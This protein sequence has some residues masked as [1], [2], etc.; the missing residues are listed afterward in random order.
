MLL[1]DQMVNA[2]RSL[3]YEHQTGLSYATVDDVAGAWKVV[4]G[5]EAPPNLYATLSSTLFGANN[6]LVSRLRDG[7]QE[8]RLRDGVV[9]VMARIDM[10][11]CNLCTA[12]RVEAVADAKLK[13]GLWGYVCRMHF[14]HNAYGLGTG[15]GQILVRYNDFYRD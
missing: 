9:A 13:Q 5:T 14:S 2:L 3:S 7:V 8:F 15:L 10:P 4:T 1:T 11:A 12:E 6:L